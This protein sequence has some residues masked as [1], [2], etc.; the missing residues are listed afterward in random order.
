M[1]TSSN[2]LKLAVFGFNGG[3][4]FTN[5]PDRYRPTWESNV[6]IAQMADRMGMEGAISA[7]RWKAF[8]RDGHY[9]GDLY[10]TFTWAAGIAAVTKRLCVM[11][12]VH[13]S[14]MH[15]IIS[16]KMSATV[17]LISNGRHGLNLV[18][19]WYPAEMGMFGAAMG[20]HD[21]RYALAE[22]WVPAF[23]RLWKDEHS[24]DYKGKFYDLKQAIIQPKSP[25]PRPVLMNA[26]GSERGREFAAKN[27]DVAFIVPQDP[28]PEAL[29]KQVD[30]YRNFAREKYGRE[31]KVWMSSYV[32][33]RASVQEAR[34]Y[35]QDYVVNQGDSE[36]IDSFMANNIG[37]SHN[38]PTGVIEQMRFAIAAGY[39]GYP[40]LGTAQDIAST[41]SMIS[42]AGVDGVLLTWMD[43]EGGLKQFGDTVMP[44]LEKT[45]LR[46]PAPVY[47]D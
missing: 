7:S 38:V 12:T 9:S 43:Y 33:Q 32:V 27:V 11:S 2:K 24:F 19:G 21:D 8:A 29:K 40:I 10:E 34:D 28:R 36:G 5:H 1:L 20:D 6:R 35:V 42:E 45:G 41:L 15:P 17:D 31:I 47:P 44:L 26:G 23:D 16:A 3:A 37:N 18:C 22:E 39:G 4:A 25:H 13:L 46:S 30:F 14:V